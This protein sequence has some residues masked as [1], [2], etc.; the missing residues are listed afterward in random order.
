MVALLTE[1]LLD[2]DNAARVGAARALGG[3]GAMA[4]LTYL[5]AEKGLDGPPSVKAPSSK[6]TNATKAT[7]R[8]AQ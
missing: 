2:S 4:T 7:R 8:S 5:I 6:A 1:L 3:A